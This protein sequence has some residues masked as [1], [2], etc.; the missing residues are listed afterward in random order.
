MSL[1]PLIRPLLFALAAFALLVPAQALADTADDII[2][3][4]T[5]DG[6]L[7]RRYDPRDLR[8]AKGR[9]EADQEEYSNCRD[10]INEALRGGRGS[11]GRGPGG[12]GAGAGGGPGAGAGFSGEPTPADL[13]AL[14][15]A[16][17][18]AREGGPPELTIDGK[19]VSPA[20]AGGLFDP[21]SPSNR[22][23][24]PLVW[25]LIALAALTGAA[26]GPAARRVAGAPR[27]TLRRLRR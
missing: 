15:A 14:D 17:R 16:Q 22:L 19:K 11:A 9:L 1:R 24:S 4:C 26:A 8:E 23:P 27:A 10:A 20:L 12:A 18:A 3:D 7:D 5:Q 6:V 25:V 2:T 13:A 21:A